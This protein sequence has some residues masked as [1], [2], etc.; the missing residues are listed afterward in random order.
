MARV[1]EHEGIDPVISARKMRQQT[2][3]TPALSLSLNRALVYLGISILV[4]PASS[5]SQASVIQAI[6]DKEQLD[7]MM[8]D[9]T[10]ELARNQASLE[11]TESIYHGL[12]QDSQRDRD[13]RIRVE[14]HLRHYQDLVASQT[15]YLSQL[16]DQQNDLQNEE[17]KRLRDLKNFS[18]PYSDSKRLAFLDMVLKPRSSNARFGESGKTRMEDLDA[19][20][21]AAIGG[22][23]GRL[24][25]ETQNRQEA[26][27]ILLDREA[28]VN[29]ILE[30]Q[31]IS[32][33]YYDERFV[34]YDKM[35]QTY[36]QILRWRPDLAIF[37]KP[38]PEPKPPET[39][40]RALERMQTTE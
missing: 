16:R 38:P 25:E 5:Q 37:F 31:G 34:L 21:F 15:R 11:E 8:E 6:E 26:S 33:G 29:T 1:P 27:T 23:Q 4:M 30:M 22:L 20:L 36:E 32:Q 3:M 9:T 14:E 13:L 18:N 19:E 12:T 40:K 17:L 39:Y 7:V 35:N 24:N 28:S 2:A 10:S